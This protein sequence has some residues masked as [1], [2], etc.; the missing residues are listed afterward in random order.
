MQW[1][2]LKKMYQVLY[3]TAEVTSQTDILF[4]LK[5]NYYILCG[6]LCC[7]RSKAHLVFSLLAKKAHN[8][9]M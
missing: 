9:D 3:L 5:I 4:I 1:V 2:M 6:F 7:A 8:Q